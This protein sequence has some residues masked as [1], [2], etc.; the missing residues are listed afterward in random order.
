MIAKRYIQ[1]AYGIEHYFPGY[2]DAY[3]GP[4]QWKHVEKKS[5]EEL[6]RLAQALHHDVDSVWLEAQVNSMRTV[7]DV[8]RG[9]TISYRQEIREVYDIEVELVP[10][11]RFEEAIKN[12]DALLPGKGTLAERLESFHDRFTLHPDNLFDVIKVINTELKKR[13]KALFPLPEDERCEIRRVNNQPWSGYNWYLGNGQSRIDLNIDLPV[14]LHTLP[15]LL[16]HEGY[17]GHH[18]EHILKDKHLCLEQQKLE[19][20][21]FLINSPEAVLAEGIAESA[22]D[23]VMTE[24][25]ITQLLEEL[26]PVAK[27]RA[28]QEDIKIFQ[29]M[30]K[31]NQDLKYVA[32]NAALLLYEEKRP[33]DE[34][35]NY[36]QTYMVSSPER[37]EK[38]LE[39]LQTPTSRSYVFTYTTGK[40]LLQDLFKKGNTQDLFSKLLH[41]AF[42]PG[43]IREW[44][45]R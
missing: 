39:F 43:M 5:L 27:V 36:L 33:V 12:L 22:L 28:T 11:K 34:V 9:E 3:S 20:S 18:T 45:K 16:A 7:I 42:T 14:R 4:E 26:L 30:Q 6:A 13:S 44:I 29:N 41:E 32:G 25:E 23:V 19:H 1:L 37:V 21:I 15:G 31:L 17:P 24:R 8:L 10:E 2:I 38:R 35:R 40:D